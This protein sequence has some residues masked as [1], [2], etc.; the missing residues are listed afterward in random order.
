MRRKWLFFA[1]VFCLLLSACGQSGAD[2][3]VEGAESSDKSAQESAE[4]QSTQEATPEQEAAA[5]EEARIAE[6][7][8]QAAQISSE[9]SALT[10]GPDIGPELERIQTSYDALTEEGRRYVEDF[11]TLLELKDAYE[12]K[13]ET[14]QEAMD[15]IDAIGEIDEGSM[16]AIEFAQACYDAVDPAFRSAVTNAAVLD[17]AEDACRQAIRDKGTA[18]TQTLIDAGQYQ[19][20]MDYAG[21][22]IADH[23]FEMGSQTELAT[24]Q[25]TA[26]LYLAWQYY[27]ANYLEDTQDLLDHLLGDAITDELYNGAWELQTRMDNYLVSSEPSNGKILSSTISGGYGELT[28]NSGSNPMLIKVEKEYD[29]SKY[30]YFYVRAD[31]SA[32]INVPDGDYVVKYASGDVYY[33]SGAEQPFGRDTSYSQADDVLEFSTSYSGNYVYYSTITLTLYAVAGGNMSSYSIDPDS[34]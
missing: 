31:S 25:Q 10:L 1:I 3:L 12:Q 23:Q 13:M 6:L 19:E 22:Y 21:Q 5:A 34:F 2:T 32:M 11:D 17:G 18:E 28:I 14:V 33:G 27:N 7:R 20:A 29:A 24:L 16:D 30:I 26:E 15:A 4:M 8:A 9:I